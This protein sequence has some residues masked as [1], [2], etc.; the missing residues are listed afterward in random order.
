MNMLRTFGLCVVTLGGIGVYFPAPGTA[1]TLATLLALYGV[2][3]FSYTIPMQCL[4]TFVCIIV[5]CISITYILPLFA[6]KKD[7]SAIVI[8]ELIGTCITFIGV[9]A[10]LH[11][12][13]IGCTV[14]RLCDIYKPLGISRMES[15]PGAY[16]IIADDVAAGI[17]AC[18]FLHIYIWLL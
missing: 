7:P 8:D 10:S 15:L 4:V 18:L 5:G 6:G 11:T 14:F 13:L 12:I 3:F 17:Y 16:G 1:A 2:S 9:S